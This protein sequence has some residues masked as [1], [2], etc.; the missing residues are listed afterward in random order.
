MLEPFVRPY[1]HHWVLERFLG[2]DILVRSRFVRWSHSVNYI[3]RP[4][5][6]RMGGPCPCLHY[7]A[8]GSIG[9]PQPRE[10]SSSIS[11]AIPKR[12]SLLEH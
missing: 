11:A 3:C 10:S 2:V 1:L 4:V 6:E 9:A 7:L 8:S 12:R 5:T